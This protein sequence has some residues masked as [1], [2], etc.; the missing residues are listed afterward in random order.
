MSRAISPEFLHD[1]KDGVLASL[2]NLVRRDDTL[3]LAL[4]GASINVYYRGG[5][6]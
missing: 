2:T 6:F 4:R 5:A 3:L 1:L